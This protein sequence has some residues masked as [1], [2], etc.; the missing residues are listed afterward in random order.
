MNLEEIRIEIDEINEKMLALFQKRMEL[1]KQVITYKL[2][3][4]IP[5]INK[6]REAEIIA[7]YGAD[8][9]FAMQFFESIIE[10]SRNWQTKL[11]IDKNIVLIGMMG[12]GKTTIG[13]I[14]EHQLA[15]PFVDVDSKIEIAAG[16]SIP[17]IFEQGEEVFRQLEACEIEK[18]AKCMPSVISTG[19]GVILQEKNMQ[20]LK[21][22]GIVFFLNRPIKAVVAD[23]A[24]KD[25]PMLDNRIERVLEIYEERLPL[26][27]KY[28]DYEIKSAKTPREVSAEIITL[29]QS[30]AMI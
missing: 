14:L 26:Y 19:G 17:E 25:R 29:L 4:Q 9:P 27:Q 13:R 22:N 28:A 24:L 18:I 1:S 5:I 15:L 8:D 23:I 10:I 11:M 21:E 12:S 16:M 2:E 20:K 7:H 30:Q 6:K 3:H